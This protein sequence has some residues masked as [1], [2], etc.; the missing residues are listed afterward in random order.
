MVRRKF[1][2]NLSSMLIGPPAIEWLYSDASKSPSSFLKYIIKLDTTLCP[3]NNISDFCNSTHL[4]YL[5]CVDLLKC[6]PIIS[7]S[8]FKKSI[9][10]TNIPPSV[11]YILSNLNT[12]HTEEKSYVFLNL[13][14]LQTNESLA[15]ELKSILSGDIVLNTKLKNNTQ[16]NPIEIHFDT[17]NLSHQQLANK[18][19]K[20]CSIVGIKATIMPTQKSELWKISRFQSNIIIDKWTTIGGNLDHLALKSM[21][22]TSQYR[23]KYLPFIT[24]TDSIDL[25]RK[26]HNH[27]ILPHS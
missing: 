12:Q 1:L 17:E 10:L 25:I 21:Y 14:W 6:S 22:S 27:Y 20:R 24:A 16:H 19:A 23:L 18:L 2:L 8:D 7:H 11:F 26:K 4:R 13:N 5:A 3:T 15:S 9:A